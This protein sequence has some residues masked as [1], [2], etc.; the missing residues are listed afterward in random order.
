MTDGNFSYGKI[1]KTKKKKNNNILWK[2]ENPCHYRLFEERKGP[3][4]HR[5]SGCLSGNIHATLDHL[6]LFYRSG[7]S[8]QGAQQILPGTDTGQAARGGELG[9]HRW[10]LSIRDPGKQMVWHILDTYSLF[11]HLLGTENDE[12]LIIQFYQSPAHYRL[13]NDLRLDYQCLYPRTSFPQKPHQL[14][15]ERTEA[16][17]NSCSKTALECPE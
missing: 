5:Y 11:C 3:F 15:G 16:R 10:C 2:Q 9:Q 13:R 7:R 17:S 4:H 6:L 12:S 1:Y 14:G 8:K